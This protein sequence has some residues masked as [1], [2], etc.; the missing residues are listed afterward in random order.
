MNNINKSGRLYRSSIELHIS[1][2][3]NRL[4]DPF[5]KQQLQE[6]RKKSKTD[7]RFHSPR[8]VTSPTI[9][10]P[11]VRGSTEVALDSAYYTAIGTL[12]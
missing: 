11:V 6:D 3:I 2:G 8:T 12:V 9:A 4:S 1:P 5:S 10:T 7:A